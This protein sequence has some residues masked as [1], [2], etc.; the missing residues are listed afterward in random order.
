MGPLRYIIE[1]NIEEEE[2]L[3]AQRPGMNEVSFRPRPT[4]MC[5]AP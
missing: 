3:W 2:E 5:T 4:T 1:N